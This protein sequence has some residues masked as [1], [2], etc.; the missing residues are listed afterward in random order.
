MEFKSGEHEGHAVCP[1]Q[2]VTAGV[3]QDAAR[4]G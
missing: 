4:Q 1:P 2:S 3:V